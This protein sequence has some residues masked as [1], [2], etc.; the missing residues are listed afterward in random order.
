MLKVGDIAPPL[1]AETTS[2]DRFSLDDAALCTVVYFY[3]KS[4]SPGCSR[5]TRAF[6]ENHDALVAAGARLVGISTDD[7]QT[8][9]AFVKELRLPFPLIGDS[10]KRISNA[11][12]VLW[13]LFGVPKRVTYVLDRSRKVLAV[14]RHELAVTRHIDDVLEFVTAYASSAR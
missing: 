2:G 12:G 4:F 7:G 6:S 11:F 8:Q 1:D 13:G 14:F 5:Q 10:D 9:C 3:P